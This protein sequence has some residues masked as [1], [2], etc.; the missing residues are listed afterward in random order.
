MRVTGLPL[1]GYPGD[2]RYV[3]AQHRARLAA[4]RCRSP[5]ARRDRSGRAATRRPDGD[6]PTVRPDLA[7]ALA[8]AFLAGE[9]TEAGLAASGAY[10]LGRR[11]AWLAPLAR[12]VRRALPPRAARPPARAGREPGVTPGGGQG[13]RG[14]AAGAA[15]GRDADG[16]RPVAG[17]GARRARRRRRLLRGVRLRARL[18]LRP[19]PT[20]PRHHRRPAP[21][22]PGQPSHRPER[23]D[24]GARGAQD[25]A[26]GD[27]ATPARRGRVADP[28][29]RRGSRVPAR[30][31]GAVLRP[32]P[33]RSQRGRA[34]R[35]RGLLRQRDRLAR[36]RHLAHRR[37]PRAGRPLPRRAGDVRAA[38]VELACGA[39]ARRRRPARRPL[40]ARPTPRGAPPAAGCPDVAGDGEPRGLPPRRPAHRAGAVVGRALHEV[41]RRPG[42][43]GRGRLGNGARHDSSTRSRRSCA[44]RASGST[45]ARPA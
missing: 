5:R 42:V 17:A 1:R 36:L 33:C 18:V 44:T 12:Q 16:R 40:A 25:P 34:A 11:T 41:R 14:R 24:P 32:S 2:H 27:A 6:L 10:V 38:P 15:G 4:L 20:G 30:R 26:Q 23:R 31:L 39:P 22:L 43:L 8:A 9:W 37:L 19:A 13:T 21:A 35:P 29:A 7:R 3:R 28:A 45:P